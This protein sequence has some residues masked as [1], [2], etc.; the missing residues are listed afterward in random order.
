MLRDWLY[1][2]DERGQTP[3]NRIFR[4]SH[5]ALTELLLRRDWVRARMHDAKIT[6]RDYG[7]AAQSLGWTSERPTIAPH[8]R[9][10]VW[11]VPLSCLS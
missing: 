11:S 5:M 7:T 8:G 1:T 6:D 3:L 2:T 9:V 10:Y 4:S